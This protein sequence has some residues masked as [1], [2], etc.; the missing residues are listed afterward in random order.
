M[1]K[2]KTLKTILIGAALSLCGTANAIPGAGGLYKL[3]AGGADFASGGGITVTGVDFAAC[4]QQLNYHMDIHTNNGGTV[5]AIQGCKL[6][7]Y[8]SFH[9]V[10]AVALEEKFSISEYKTKLENI[11]LTH[12]IRMD[13]EIAALEVEYRIEEFRAEVAEQTESGK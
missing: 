13:V 10:R 11:K 4:N 3:W 1:I 5:T 6:S 12:Q 2:T 9:Q 7:K 8:G